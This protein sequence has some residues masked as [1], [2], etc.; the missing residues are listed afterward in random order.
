MSFSFLFRKI[1]V[2]FNRKVPFAYIVW[3]AFALIAVL[4][5][6][7]H[8][9]FN[10][11]LIFKNVFW[12]VIHQ[13]N[14]YLAYPAEYE[15]HNYYGPVFSFIIA[16]FA[17][18]PNF[19]GVI[20]WV[21]ANATLLFVAIRQLPFRE[22]G[23]STIL[24]ISAIEMMTSSHNVQFNCM[25]A[26][27]III[28]YTFINKGK[29]FWGTFFIAL[30]FLA[31]I[32][33]IVGILFFV[34]SKNKPKFIGFFI[35]WLIVLFLLPMLIS[36]PG[37]IIQTYQDWFHSLTLKNIQNIN[38]ASVNFQDL[39]VMGIIRRVFRYDQLSSLSVILPAILLL[40]LPLLRF[41]LL[42]N[43]VFQLDYLCLSLISV[44]IFSSS[45]ESATYVIAMVGV[46]IWF[47]TNWH[48]HKKWYII[49][50]VAALFITSL[51]STDLVPQFIKHNIIRAYALKALPCFIVWLI[52]IYDVAFKSKSELQT[53]ELLLRKI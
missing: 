23:I 8:H 47:V 15:D 25:I 2:G 33:G 20:F 34:F 46:S 36:S 13:K 41:N 17:V 44:V 7:F 19:L 39:T 28:S 31:K 30:G 9:S 12:H 51:G 11:Y 38:I 53:P 43:S 29:D 37:F 14:L 18:L 16:P 32:Y 1:N 52:L 22:K 5:E 26:A 27:S 49:V 4:A 48:R 3:F 10:N 21:M 50:L 40:G 24:L 42:R 35:F 6:F 45:A